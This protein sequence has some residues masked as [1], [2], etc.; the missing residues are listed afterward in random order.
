MNNTTEEQTPALT[1]TEQTPAQVCTTQLGEWIAKLGIGNEQCDFHLRTAQRIDPKEGVLMQAFVV[2]VH[3]K[4]ERVEPEKTEEP[5]PL[6]PLPDPPTPGIAPV[7]N[8]PQ[9]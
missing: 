5:N 8:P 7:E 2:E 9:A 1:G 4:M 3:R 6:P